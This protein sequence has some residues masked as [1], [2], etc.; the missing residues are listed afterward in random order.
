MRKSGLLFIL[1]ASS[2]L[3][4]SLAADGA[5]P[6]WEPTTINQPGRYV[7]TRNITHNVNPVISIDADNVFLD[8]NGFK[9]EGDA[10]IFA[11]DVILVS[12][13]GVTPARDG[14]AQGTAGA[15]APG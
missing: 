4:A 1:C 3:P 14:T 7:V 8:L 2:W 10:Q 9:I 6:I 12:G 11:A 13:D 5:I 15:G